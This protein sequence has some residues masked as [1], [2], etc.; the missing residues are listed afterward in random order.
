MNNIPNQTVSYINFINSTR[1]YKLSQSCMSFD[2]IEEQVLQTVMISWCANTHLT[3]T[4]VI[5]TS[6]KGVSQSTVHRRL[7]SLRKMSMITHAVDE[8]DTRIKYVILE[9][10]MFIQRVI[11]L[12]ISIRLLLVL[13]I[14]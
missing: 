9:L 3:V 7:R 8:I 5:S 13:T 10:N 1:D 12:N 4:D 11:V 6:M 14:L 2:F